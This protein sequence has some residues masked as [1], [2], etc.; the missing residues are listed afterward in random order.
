M[1]K[2]VILIQTFC[3]GLVVTTAVLLVTPIAHAANC[4]ATC[5]G[6]PISVSGYWCSCNDY[7][8]CTYQLQQGGYNYMK[9]CR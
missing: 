6:G 9:A 2:W 1:K 8:G 3:L 4:S 5:T 7:V